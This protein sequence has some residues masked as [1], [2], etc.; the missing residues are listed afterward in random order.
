MAKASAALASKIYPLTITGKDGHTQRLD[1]KG[2]NLNYY[3]SLLSP[4]ITANLVFED[5]GNAMK[6]KK[7][8]DR[9]ER[10]G[11]IYNALPITGGEELSFK[12][13]GKLGKL[14]FT[15]NPLYVNGSVNLDQ[16]SQRESVILDIVSKGAISNQESTVFQKYTG[17]ISDNAKTLVSQFLGT[18]VEVDS[19]ANSYSFVGNS[20]SVF[21]VLCSL[22]SKSMPDKGNP[23]F[24][25][26][27]TREGFKFKSIDDLISQGPIATYYKSG[28]S[29]ANLDNDDNDFKIISFSVVKNQSLINSLKSGIYENRT[30]FFNPKTFKEEEIICKLNEAGG[31]SKGGSKAISLDTSLGKSAELPEVRSF[32]RTHYDILDVGTLNPDPSS[33]ETTGAKD[34]QAQSTMRY[35]SLFTQMISLQV[36]CNPKLKAGDVIK[37]NFEILSTD[38]KEMG[39]SDPVQSGNYLILN[40]C[41][42][43][44][45]LRSFTS[46]TLIRD[47]YGL[48]TKNSR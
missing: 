44:D 7:K 25:F 6:Y 4:N 46:M 48:Y 11:S 13:S 43:F 12:I 31:R 41:H 29:K 17:K 16:E 3:E 15:N 35:N 5:T 2:L 34:W 10:S 27:E 1:G 8:Y 38:G 32:T 9:Q 45:R 22:A 30:I 14:D 36:P 33:E 47:T 24:F 39:S 42:S 20:S 40:L 28:A 37:C 19:T 18:D 21:D 26:Y 23:G